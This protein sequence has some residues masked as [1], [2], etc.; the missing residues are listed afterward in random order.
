VATVAAVP[1]L[2]AAL[3]AL[4]GALTA[5]IVVPPLAAPLAWAAALLLRGLQ[6]VARLAAAVPG[7]HG[8]I[9]PVGV[10]AALVAS[11]VALLSYRWWAARTKRPRA[12]AVLDAGHG[13]ARARAPAVGVAVAAALLAANGAGA[14]LGRGSNALEIHAI[15]VG[16]GDAIAIRTPAGRWFLV[17][18]GPASA[19]YDAGRARVV[20]YLLS[21]GV[22]RLDVLVLTHPDADHIGGAGAVLEA[23]DV[24]VVVDPGRAAGKPRFVDLL[25]ATAQA[26]G[27]WVGGWAGRELRAGQVN[28][29][30]LHP[31][32]PAEGG[33]EGNDAS[34]VFM[35]QW[36]GFRALFTGDAESGAERSLVATHGGQLRAGFLK[37]G[38]HGSAT[39][40]G[41]AL[42]EAVRPSI[43]LVPVGRRN[44]YGHPD[45]LVMERLRVSGARVLRTDV[46][47]NVVLRVDADGHVRVSAQRPPP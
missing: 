47:G 33:G 20:P 12:A 42:L 1:W 21:R 8:L 6:G 19:T 25:D 26:R 39:S 34:V 5:S 18:A 16:Q 43:A 10:Q 13:T 2:A 4:V 46:L 9:T 45:P 37:V 27:R 22:R 14:A 38:H 23:F 41:A 29:L 35:L 28:L 17:D 36:R 3:P 15:D 11:A 31:P 30:F 24:G 40:T 7:G 32:P 44:R